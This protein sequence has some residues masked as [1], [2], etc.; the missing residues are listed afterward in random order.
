MI[1][2]ELLVGSVADV[3]RTLWCAVD[4]RCGVCCAVMCSSAAWQ[5]WCVLVPCAVSP[6]H[7]VDIHRRLLPSATRPACPRPTADCHPPRHSP[8]CSIPQLALCQLDEACI[9]FILA[10]V[11]GGLAYLHGAGRLHRRVRGAAC[12]AVRLAATRYWAAPR[13]GHTEATHTHTRYDAAC[14]LTRSSPSHTQTHRDIKAANILV[15]SEGAVKMSDFGV[16][17]Q[18]TGT[19]G[20]RCV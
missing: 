14:I 3:V 18:L 11:I 8:S 12:G 13:R 19:L 10:R 5:T 20:Y 6:W 4:V 7:T 15:S 1:V 16:S 17:G 9:A 2:M